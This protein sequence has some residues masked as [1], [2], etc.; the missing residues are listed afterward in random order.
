M[1]QPTINNSWHMKKEINV[2]H[3][4]TTVALV[5]SGLWVL[6]DMDKRI[7]VNAQSISHVQAQRVEDQKRIEKRLDS[8]DKKLD[9]LLKSK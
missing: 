3:I 2:A 5:V 9:E 7:A 6:S 8:I 4:I 1:T